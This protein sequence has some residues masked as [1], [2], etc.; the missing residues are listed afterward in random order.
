MSRS[1]TTLIA[2]LAM[3]GLAGSAIAQ[4]QQSAPAPQA[5]TQMKAD[6]SDAELQEFAAIQEDVR[7]IR[8]EF[9]AGQKAAKDESEVKT[10]Q[11]EA[12][13]ELDSVIAE[14]SLSVEE[15]NQIAALIQQNQSVQKRY[16]A[17]A[18]Q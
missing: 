11:S 3:A 7:T 8:K 18:Q 1:F 9:Q 13:A 15:L 16:V 2:G 10:L 14:S 6:V 17:I 5:Q 4:E 12:Q